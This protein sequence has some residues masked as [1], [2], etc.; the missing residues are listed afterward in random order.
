MILIVLFASKL[1][2]KGGE[3]MGNRRDGE[4]NMKGDRMRGK[5]RGKRCAGTLLK[6]AAGIGMKP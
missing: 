3:E 1:C 6:L 2:F 4:R 5:R